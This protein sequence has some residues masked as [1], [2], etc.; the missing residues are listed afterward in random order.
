MNQASFQDKE[1]PSTEETLVFLSARAFAYDF[2]KCTFL[3][4]PSRKFLKLLIEGE[5]VQAFPFYDNDTDLGKAIDTM[6]GYLKQ[7]NITSKTGFQHL[8][9]DYTRMFIGPGEVPAP[10]W[11]SI[12]RDVERLHFSKE[13]LEVRA[14]Y[15][16]YNLMPRRFGH[17]P[18][19]HIGLELDFMH[20]LCEMAK[21]KTENTDEKGLLEILEDQK[22]FLDDH[23]LKWVPA[24]SRDV[25]KSAETDFYKGAAQLLDAYL[26][27][28]RKML[29]AF[30]AAI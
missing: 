22:T 14:A 30:I 24:W 20:K 13:T 16:K 12:Y 7:P 1:K 17:D 28:D 21:K 11:E 25:V 5:W 10:P 8:H 6:L 9:W 27:L 19:D 26:R 3:Q 15:C 4:E 18:D 2:L 29:E 23:L